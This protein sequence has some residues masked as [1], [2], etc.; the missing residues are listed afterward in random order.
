MAE[1]AVLGYA[2]AYVIINADRKVLN[3]SPRT[4]KYLEPSTGAPNADLL[5]MA[6][7]GLRL[8]GLALA[9]PG[10]RSA[11]LIRPPRPGAAPAPLRPWHDAATTG[12]PT[13]GF[14]VP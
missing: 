9:A 11:S 14:P 2:P 3:F 8:Q 12:A 5:L 10:A 4:G 7:R 13:V 6:R 1:R